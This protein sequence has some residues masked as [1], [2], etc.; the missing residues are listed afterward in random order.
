MK[1]QLFISHNGGVSRRKAFDH[2]ING[3]VTVNDNVVKE[4]SHM[5]EPGEDKVMLQG[6]EIKLTAYEYIML[7]KPTGYVTT[8]EAQFDQTA[9]M[10]LM[11]ANLRHLKPVGRLDKDT[12]GLLLL[13]NDGELAN[14]LAHPSFDV[15]KTYHVRVARKM[16]YREKDRLEQGVVIDGFQTAPAEVANINYFGTT[17]TEF[18]LTIH[19][20]HKHQVRLMCHEV[21]HDVERLTRIAQGPLKL[22]DLKVGEWRPLTAEELAELH[23]IGRTHIAPV[24]KSHAPQRRYSANRDWSSDRPE[25]QRYS[26]PG[27]SRAEEQR[28]ERFEGRSSARPASD[29]PREARSYSSDRPRESRPYSSGSREGRPSGERREYRPRTDRPYSSDRPRQDR[30]YS[31]G[32]R[33]DRPREERSYS[34][35]PRHERPRGDRPYSSDRPRESRSYSSGP[36]TDRPR[37]D[38]PY[39]SD[40]PR[41]DRPY[42]SDRPRES[43]PY[44]SGPRTDRP[45]SDRPYSSDRPRESR[46]YSSG[47]RTDRPRSDRPYSS[48]RPRESRSYS[49][50]PRTDRPRS[51]R[52]YSSGPREGGPSGE[53]R[54]YKPYG[55]RRERRDDRP[56]S[57]ATGPR[58]FGAN[59]PFGKKPF[60]SKPFGKK[61][62]NKKPF[63]R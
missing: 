21:G 48:D 51:D 11:P 46:P 1:L 36:R 60:G 27:N 53:R 40:R 54:E 8:C 56:S 34:S 44:S 4:P 42:S 55:E 35:G 19:E 24:F 18:D 39:S 16:E 20:G 58:N 22:G 29:R 12:Q 6:R 43:R 41:T 10:S 37:A 57:A 50:G 38:R 5:V 7:N 23:A 49:S 14:R 59:K 2:I 30:P 28:T 26:T 45:R 47:P 9:V 31:S 17:A 33:S 15:N 62:F 3:D 52:P 32:P 13:T 25:G 63:S 61:P